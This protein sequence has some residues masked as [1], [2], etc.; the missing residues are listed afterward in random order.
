MHVAMV[1]VQAELA[2][3]ELVQ[4]MQIVHTVLLAMT[5]VMVMMMA[6]VM[7]MM[8]AMG[9]ALRMLCDAHHAPLGVRQ[10]RAELRERWQGCGPGLQHRVTLRYVSHH[11]LHGKRY[12]FSFSFT[13][14]TAA[15]APR[16]PAS[17]NRHFRCY[18]RCSL[19]HVWSPVP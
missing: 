18:L 7:V 12:I 19:F 10:P 17:Y 9:F 13:V 8:M 16:P 2:P 1:S 14:T 11:H 15:A 4:I 3:V 5:S 6:T